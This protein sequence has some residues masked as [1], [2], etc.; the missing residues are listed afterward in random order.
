V[1]HDLWISLRSLLRVSNDMIRHDSSRNAMIYTAFF[2]CLDYVYNPKEARMRKILRDQ[3]RDARFQIRCQSATTALTTVPGSS[4]R[5][6]AAQHQQWG[7]KAQH[8]TFPPG[9]TG[10]QAH[11][12][13]GLVSSRVSHHTSYVTLLFGW[14]HSPD[15]CHMHM[16]NKCGKLEVKILSKYNLLHG[17]Y[18][19]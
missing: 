13:H 19:S 12:R 14:N 10:R 5:Q 15:I 16:E 2:R 9:I 3:G 1:I 17:A 11:G 6:Q 18:S 4:A 8:Q 7:N